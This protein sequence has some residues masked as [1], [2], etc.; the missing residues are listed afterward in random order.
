MYMALFILQRASWILGNR[1]TGASCRPLNQNY[2]AAA[3]AATEP[4]AA[5][6]AA[7][8]P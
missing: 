6:P 1:P 4:A 2:A 3:P 8:Q 5:Q 7:P